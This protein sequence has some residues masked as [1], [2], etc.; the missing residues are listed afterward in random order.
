[1]GTKQTLKNEWDADFELL[2]VGTVVVTDRGHTATI[3]E[4][5]EN[6]KND[7]PGYILD[8]E[9][10]CYHSQIVRIVR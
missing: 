1:M 9:H 3:I 6:V 4:A 7:S 8:N 2:T 10:W 5:E